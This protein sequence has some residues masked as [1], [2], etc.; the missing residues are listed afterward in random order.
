MV[1][2]LLYRPIEEVQRE[3]LAEVKRLID[4]IKFTDALDETAL[5]LEG[6]DL[7]GQRIFMVLHHLYLTRFCLYCVLFDMRQLLRTAEAKVRKKAL[8]ILRFWLN[9]ICVHTVSGHSEAQSC[10]PF[11]LVGTHK[12]LGQSPIRPLS[13]LSV[14]LYC[15]RS[16]SSVFCVIAFV[17]PLRK[18][19]PRSQSCYTRHS[20][21]TRHGPG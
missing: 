16:V 17:I 10:A 18:T 12:D 14:Q 9:S 19:T 1:L 7:G 5:I 20:A 21:R 2:A 6:W 8:G 11:V 13:V 3:E 15:V 4:D